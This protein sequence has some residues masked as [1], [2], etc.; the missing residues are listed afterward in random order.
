[1]YVLS[2]SSGLASDLAFGTVTTYNAPFVMPF[3]LCS[4]TRNYSTSNAL[5]PQVCRLPDDILAALGVVRSFNTRLNG[6]WN[7]LPPYAVNFST[8]NG[9]LAVGSSTNPTSYGRHQTGTGTGYALADDLSISQA[10]TGLLSE[11]ANRWSSNSKVL[12][13]MGTDFQTMGSEEIVV[14]PGSS[15][16]GLT[17]STSGTNGVVYR[18]EYF[19][20]GTFLG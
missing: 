17:L 16:T 4:Q 2:S 15:P 8:S 12:I 14:A 20:M 1:M 3:G 6:L 19:L 7:V 18:C 13:G 9:L 5:N 11:T 10:T